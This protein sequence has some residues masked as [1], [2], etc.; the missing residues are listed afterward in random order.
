MK[1]TDSLQVSLDKRSYDILIGEGLLASA[2][3]H[4]SAATGDGTCW[5]ISDENVAPHY[6]DT[7]T[8]SL[9]EKDLKVAKII[10]PAGEEHKNFNTVEALVNAVLDG[11]P[12]RNSTLLALGGGVIGDITGF[13][14][15]NPPRYNHIQHQRP[16]LHKWMALSAAKPALILSTAKIGGHV[17]STAISFSRYQS[18]RYFRK[19]LLRVMSVRKYGLIRDSNF[20]VGLNKTVK[21]S[22][23]ATAK[24]ESM[25]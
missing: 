7:V 10:L 5:I 13:S 17:L 4:I 1:F 9:S 23:L 22:L 25:R 16:Y 20:F 12:E 15:P 2:G 11:R 18:A 21:L 24:L 8:R 3:E 14:Q 19:E 6:L